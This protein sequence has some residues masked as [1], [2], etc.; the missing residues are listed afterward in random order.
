MF[1]FKTVLV[2]TAAFKAFPLNLDPMIFFE[3]KNTNFESEIFW[4]DVSEF[5]RCVLSRHL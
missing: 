5:N 3:K 1:I 2:R 4:V